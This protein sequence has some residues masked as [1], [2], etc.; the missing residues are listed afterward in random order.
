MIWYE[1][2]WGYRYYDFEKEV[3]EWWTKWDEE[4]DCY[5]LNKARFKITK[6][7]NL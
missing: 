7:N 6:I 2:L 1:P 3:V 4:I 5:K